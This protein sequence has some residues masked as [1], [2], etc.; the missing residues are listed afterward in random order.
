[1]KSRHHLFLTAVALGVSVFALSTAAAMAQT[2]PTPAPAA[3]VRHTVVS[4][5]YD[6]A[7]HLTLTPYVWAPTANGDRKSVV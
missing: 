3:P 6:G 1:M 5:E 4:D 2:A 7:T